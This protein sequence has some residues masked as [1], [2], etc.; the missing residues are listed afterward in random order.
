MGRIEEAV[1]GILLIFFNDP[2]VNECEFPDAIC[3]VCGEP[4]VD[5][6]WCYVVSLTGDE[7]TVHNRCLDASMAEQ[8]RQS[9]FDLYWFHTSSEPDDWQRAAKL[10][11][12]LLSMFEMRRRNQGGLEGMER[13]T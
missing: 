8:L 12:S 11:E 2:M 9:L 7:T 5:K 4:I 1:I 13:A 3:G 6:Q 10:A